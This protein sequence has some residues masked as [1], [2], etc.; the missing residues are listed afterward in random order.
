VSNGL[1][2]SQCLLE[3]I[4]GDGSQENLECSAVVFCGLYGM[5]QEDGLLKGLSFL[6]PCSTFCLRMIFHWMSMDSNIPSSL[7]DF[8]DFLHFQL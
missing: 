5:G 7:L 8:W 6:V 1:C 2:Q 4:V 3:L